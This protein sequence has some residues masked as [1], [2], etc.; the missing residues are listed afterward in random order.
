MALMV[1]IATV[2]AA[3]FTGRVVGVTDGDSITQT[4]AIAYPKP[5]ATGNESHGKTGSEHKHTP[6][7]AFVG[8][9]LVM[10]INGSDHVGD[11]VKA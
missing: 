3:S 8:I 7:H 5:S 9:D 1:F 2:E 6:E 10:A 4:H 11:V